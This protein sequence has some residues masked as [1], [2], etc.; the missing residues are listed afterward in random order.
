MISS[1]TLDYKKQDAGRVIVTKANSE[2]STRTR[3]V[4]VRLE[5]DF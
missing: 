1:L 3:N 2:K 5:L 4:V